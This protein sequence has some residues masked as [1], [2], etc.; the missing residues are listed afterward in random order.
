MES[1]SLFYTLFRFIK[2]VIV[3]I[4]LGSQRASAGGLRIKRSIQSGAYQ[5]EMEGGGLQNYR[6]GKFGTKIFGFNLTLLVK[7]FPV[8][9]ISDYSFFRP[10]TRANWFG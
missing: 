8:F 3:Y 10:M 7:I 2:T 1:L 5:E 9:F 6:E 4:I